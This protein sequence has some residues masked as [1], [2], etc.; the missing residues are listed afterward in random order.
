MTQF[1]IFLII[2]LAGILVGYYLA[3][4]K[5]TRSVNEHIAQLQKEKEENKHKILEY[6]KGKDK[7]ANDEIEQLLSV[8]D[9]TTE[10]YLNELEK[11]GHLVQIGRTGRNTYYKLL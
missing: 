8:S 4:R 1:I 6:A 11:E 10:R 2:G 3:V 9:A 7:I 5:K